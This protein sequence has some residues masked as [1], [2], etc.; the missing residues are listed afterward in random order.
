MSWC[1]D[2]RFGD[3]VFAVCE[4]LCPWTRQAWRSDGMAWAPHAEAN[5]AWLP[6]LTLASLLGAC[7]TTNPESAQTE[8]ESSST[9]DSS[10]DHE[11]GASD[12]VDAA[13]SGEAESTLTLTTGV[14]GATANGFKSR[15]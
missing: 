6:L 4:F 9:G 1:A 14:A 13:S 10:P 8:V 5:L 12:A 3:W 7:S 2:L 15:G 11:S